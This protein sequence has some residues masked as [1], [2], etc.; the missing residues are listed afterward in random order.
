MDFE[1]PLGRKA[2]RKL[3]GEQIVW[4]T[5]VDRLGRPQP[6]PVWFHWGGEDLL[7]LSQPKSAKVRQ[8]AARPLV[9]LHFNS[10]EAGNEVIV[11]QAQ[12]RRV[13]GVSAERLKAYLRKYRGG[14]QDLEATPESFQAD[15]S[16]L[17]L[18]QP[19]SLRGF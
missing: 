1:S 13:E 7:V 18:L 6:R 11:L 10:D 16:V 19:T 4:L 12:A 15:Y 9:A 2:L 8:I 3:K 17:F 5:S 14:L